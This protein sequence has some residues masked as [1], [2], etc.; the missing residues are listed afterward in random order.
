MQ[1]DRGPFGVEERQRIL[2]C[3]ECAPFG[4]E[5]GEVFAVRD[6]LSGEVGGGLG[7]RGYGS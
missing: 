3:G 5:R 4:R 7:V 6:Q 2:G 1:P